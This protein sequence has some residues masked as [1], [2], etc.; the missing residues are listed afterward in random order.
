VS[1]SCQHPLARIGDLVADVAT[2]NPIRD[3][4]EGD[5]KYIDL[6]SVDQ[7]SKTITE[8]PPIPCGDAPS[9][10]RQL[11][12]SGD[13]L[14]S[15]VR[16]NLNG[17]ARVP[18]HLHGATASTGFC[19]L[20]A[21]ER[22]L[23]GEFLFHWVRTTQFVREMVRL[24][25]GA[26]Y[27]AVSDRIVLDSAIPLPPIAEQRRIAAILD[28]AEA[29]RAKRRQAIAL[30]EDIKQALFSDLLVAAGPAIRTVTVNDSM[31]AI[32][33]YRG[34][35]PTKSDSGVPLVTARVVKGGELLEPTEFIPEADYIGWM[36]RGFPQAGDVLFTT[37]APLGEVAQLDGRRV[38]LAQ[39]LIVLRGKSGLIDNKFLMYMLT[40][41]IVR[42]QIE[43]RSTGSTV[44]GIRQ[45]EL[46]KVM[47]PIPPLVLQRAFGLRIATLEKLKI[48]QRRS[49]ARLNELFAVLQC[50]AFRGEL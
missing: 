32:I 17:V 45:S 7:E 47:L 29:L 13:V 3:G 9:R 37:E 26:S 24:A 15:T 1:A 11:V 48:V 42:S 43:A 41:P 33:D 50:R 28:K 4:G 23:A 6:S 34:K 31:E 36:S 18:T 27:P 21:D 5:F 10:A 25:T 35:S 44:R 12:E 20:R 39:R 16:P 38:A 2:W 14:V 30:I 19:V 22:E 46:R 8:N 49:L 40:A